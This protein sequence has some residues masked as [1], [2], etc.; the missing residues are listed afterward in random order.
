MKHFYVIIMIALSGVFF[1]SCKKENN[2]STSVHENLYPRKMIYLKIDSLT[3][4]ED[5]FAIIDYYKQ[6]NQFNYDSIGY[7]YLDSNFVKLKI[8]SVSANILEVVP[9]NPSMLLGF[10]KLNQLAFTNN[11]I[12]QLKDDYSDCI[13]LGDFN[14][15]LQFDL[16]YDSIK[17]IKAY[18][19]YP[20]SGRCNGPTSTLATYRYSAQEDTCYIQ[21]KTDFCTKQD[22][23]LYYK[24]NHRSNIPFLG[25][26][27]LALS[28]CQEKYFSNFNFR[29][30]GFDLY[31]YTEYQYR[32]IKEVRTGNDFANL[33]FSYT[34]QFNTDDNVSEVLVKTSSHGGMLQDYKIKFYY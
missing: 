22:T 27:Y 21:Y 13:S 25:Y 15:N 32:F 19:F 34:Y 20:I 9:E 24:D 26:T 11:N 12:T 1:F 6:S 17:R 28:G 16:Q 29:Y 30:P 23:I 33:R 18:S 14:Y 4:A 5:T 3:N 7:R 2:R 10:T 8:N 31:K